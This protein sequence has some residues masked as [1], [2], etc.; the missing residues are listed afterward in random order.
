MRGRG[1]KDKRPFIL[2]KD[3]LVFLE[4]DHKDA[5]VGG[6]PGRP[7]AKGPGDRRDYRAGSR[8]GGGR[9]RPPAE[10]KPKWPGTIDPKCPTRH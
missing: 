8:A 3:N 4:F 2:D 1:K 5:V 9:A 10:G 7:A 6:S